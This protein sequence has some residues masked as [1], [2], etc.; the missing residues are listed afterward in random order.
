MLA[1]AKIF[2]QPVAK[3]W[4]TAGG[5]QLSTVAGR[6]FCAG[7]VE[8]DENRWGLGLA[9]EGQAQSLGSLGGF[10]RNKVRVEGNEEK[11]PGRERAPTMQARQ[12]SGAV[13]QTD[14]AVS[15]LKLRVWVPL[16]GT[17]VTVLGKT[18]VAKAG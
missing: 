17:D 16:D 9:E 12:D 18:H 13:I 15:V 10:G 7:V 11:I 14:N 3:T 1:P 4:K 5:F 2:R 8:G 6:A